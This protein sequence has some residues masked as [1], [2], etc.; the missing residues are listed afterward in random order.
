MTSDMKT[1]SQACLALTDAV[2]M[3]KNSGNTLRIVTLDGQLINAGGSMT[4]GSA[5]RGSGILSRANE[6]EKLSLE[7]ERLRE[8]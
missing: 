2:R 7:R 5:A 1:Y 6:L 4:G 8:N 3:S